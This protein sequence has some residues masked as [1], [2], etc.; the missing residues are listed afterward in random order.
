MSNFYNTWMSW[1]NT[2]G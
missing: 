1:E 2:E